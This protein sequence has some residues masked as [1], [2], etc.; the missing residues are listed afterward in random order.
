MLSMGQSSTRIQ[1]IGKEK[2]REGE[3]EEKRNTLTG[4]ESGKGWQ[5]GSQVR[6]VT[7]I[8]QRLNTNRESNLWV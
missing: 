2:E 4:R 8:R 5:N 1:S 3:R 7:P 6:A